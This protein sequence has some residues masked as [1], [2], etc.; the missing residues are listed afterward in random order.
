[1]NRLTTNR[2]AA[3][4]SPHNCVWIPKGSIGQIGGFTYAV[5]TRVP[6]FPRTVNEEDCLRCPLWQE[7]PDMLDDR[8]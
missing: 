4:A 7:P 6:D 5:C 8:F 3:Q 1:M 2:V